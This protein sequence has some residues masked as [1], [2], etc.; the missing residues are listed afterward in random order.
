MK[1]DSANQSDTIY[2]VA[3]NEMKKLMKQ[4]YP[5][6]KTIAFREDFSQGNHC[7]FSFSPELISERAL[8][9]NVSESEYIENTA[10]IIN[11]DITLKYILCF[12]NDECCRA[13]LEFM[14]CYLK[15]KGYSQN[16]KVQIVDEYTLEVNEEY[17]II[18][19]K[20]DI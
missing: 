9:W 18:N 11:L 6:R 12:G 2:I 10:Q 16:I 5:E 3:G 13:N 7:C 14:I 8:Y 4:K 15:H 17:D 20:N 1:I 19:P